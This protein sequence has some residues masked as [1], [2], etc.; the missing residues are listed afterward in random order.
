MRRQVEI[1]HFLI[2]IDEFTLDKIA[3]IL[4][5]VAVNQLQKDWCDDC[6]HNNHN[7]NWAKKVCLHQS[8]GNTLGCNNQ[9][10]FAAGDHSNA[11]LNAFTVGIAAELCAQAAAKN[12][13]NTGPQNKKNRKQDD[14]G[15]HWR[16]LDLCADAGKEN[17]REQH[18]RSD[19]K[20]RSYIGDLF[21][22]G[23]DQ[24]RYVGACDIGNAKEF[25][26]DIGKDQAESERKYSVAA[27]VARRA[28]HPIFDQLMHDNASDQAQNEKCRDFNQDDADFNAWVCKAGDQRQ[29]NNTEDIVDQWRCRNE[30]IA[31]PFP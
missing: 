5:P 12:F 28:A 9:G 2:L 18:I 10:D 24:A 20:P 15:C 13:G 11:D 1:S 30:S 16:N 21:G 26:G 31:F 4:F 3:V 19:F 7:Y 17:R 23:N 29:G 25:F 6:C 14:G 27:Q 22:V 8:G